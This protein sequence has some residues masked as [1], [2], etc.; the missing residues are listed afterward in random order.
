M[1]RQYI[2]F[3]VVELW[4][5]TLRPIHPGMLPYHSDAE[6]LWETR[7]G[8]AI[9]LDEHTWDAYEDANADSICECQ[10]ERDLVQD[11]RG[12]YWECPECGR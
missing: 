6:R 12:T 3:V 1:E 8:T 5:G 10:T 2:R 11:T 9:I 4:H 7:R